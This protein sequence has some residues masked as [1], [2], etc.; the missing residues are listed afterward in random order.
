MI[1][2]GTAAPDF[3]LVD[4]HGRNLDSLGLRG[5]RFAL[6]FFPL[7]FSQVCGDELAELREHSELFRTA[8]TSLIGIS[9]DS[10]FALRAWSDAAAIQFPLVSDF[11]PHGAV[12]RSYGVF[13]DSTGRAKRATFVI[14]EAGIVR[15]TI[16]VPPHE[17]RTFAQYA[18][19]LST[20]G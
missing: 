14:D 5:S 1:E 6:V 12:A 10:V 15:A 17:A 9:V 16:R 19:A 13:D 11:W 18:D 20:L 3:R 2:N 8:R 4:Q 7:A